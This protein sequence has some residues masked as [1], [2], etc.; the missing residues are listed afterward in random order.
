[1]TAHSPRR[2]RRRGVAASAA[3]A[4][5]IGPPLILVTGRE[6]PD[7]QRVFPELD[8]CDIAVVENGALLYEPETGAENAA[9]RTAAGGLRGAPA[10]ARRRRRCRS[11]GASSRPGSRMETVV[12]EAIRELGLELQIIFN[13]GAVMV[14][15]RR[16]Q[17]GDRPAAALERARA[18]AA[19]CRRPSATPRTTTRSAVCGCSVAVANALPAVKETADW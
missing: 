2:H 19:Q 5:G 11:A 17:Q 4:E 8:L 3:A 15:P 16:R 10:R 6:L 12:L 14:L 9:D 1:M 18:L 13:K 7:L